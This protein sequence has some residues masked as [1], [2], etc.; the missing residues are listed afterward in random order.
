MKKGILVLAFIS[1][2]L[3]VAAQRQIN[4]DFDW[5]FILQDSPIFAE[6][7][8]A[9]QQWEDVQLPH[10]WNIRMKFDK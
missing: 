5:K 4:F 3:S 1:I 7:G 10:D 9:D 8:Y 6:P 2:F